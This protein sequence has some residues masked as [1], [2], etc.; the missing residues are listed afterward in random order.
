MSSGRGSASSPSG[1]GR[2]GEPGDEIAGRYRLEALLG[3]GAQGE[4]WR[5]VDA[6]VSAPVAI[7]LLRGGMDADPARIR[8]EAAALR[9]IRVPGVVRLQD[10]GVFGDR[11]FLVLDL[12]EGDPFP[13]RRMPVAWPDLL[14]VATALLDTLG[15]VHA[16]GIVHRDLKPANVLVRPDGAPV[17]LDFGLSRFDTARGDDLTAAGELLGTPAYLAP[18]QIRG[19]PVTARTDL[20]AVGVLLYEALSG[21]LPHEAEGWTGLLRQKLLR[22]PAPL[23]EVAPDVPLVVAAAVD[24][25]LSATPADRP[26]TALEAKHALL[27]ESAP[28]RRLPW[29]GPASIVD[30]TVMDLARGLSVDVAAEPGDGGTRFLFEVESRLR[31]AGETPA[32]LARSTR[33]FVSLEP[34]IG[35]LQ[36][37]DGATL[38]EAVSAAA[39]ALEAFFR[40]GGALLV[41]SAEALDPWSAQ[42]IEAAR[43]AG[44]VLRLGPRWEGDVRRLPALSEADL[45]AFFTGRDRLFHLR[46][47]AAKALFQRTSGRVGRVADELD[48][49]TRAG[50]ALLDGASYR[51]DRSSLDALE[52]G[53][54]VA[55]PPAPA[56]VEYNLLPAHLAELSAWAFL[57]GPLATAPFLASILGQ[58]RWRVEADIETLVA[59]GAG[60]LA[61]ETGALVVR[62]L[63]DPT[64]AWPQPRVR[65]AH[66]RIAETLPAGAPS[67]I[68]HLL[69]AGDAESEE[70]GRE[71]HATATRLFEEGRSGRAVAVIE[72]AL[73]G[74]RAAEGEAARIR[75]SLFA[76][77]IEIAQTDVVPRSADRIL[78]ELGRVANNQAGN[79]PDGSKALLRIEALA[80]AAVAISVEPGRAPRILDGLPPFAGGLSPKERAALERVK[81]ATRMTAA[82]AR[83]EGDETATLA[84]A[85]EWARSAGDPE[86]LAA[87]ESWRGRHCYR[88]GRFE[89]A[90]SHHLRAASGARGVAARVAARLNAA[91][92]MIEAFRP[93]D[94]ARVAK[95]A[96]EEAR[97]AR[98]PFLEARAEW[99]SRASAYRLE[100]ESEADLDLVE[101]VETLD[102]AH[103][104]GPVCLT[105]A[106][107]A[108]R[109]G[110]RESARDLALRAEKAWTAAR[111]HEELS[112]LARVLA[113]VCGEPCTEEERSR[114]LERAGRCVVPGVGI[115]VIGL[116]GWGG[117]RVSVPEEVESRLLIGLDPKNAR[118]RMDVLSRAECS[119]G[120]C[121]GSPS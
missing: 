65:A 32:I 59:G 17:I 43:G 96:G 88:L 55:R 107:F 57:S 106:T 60:H 69:K 112:L 78:Y 40:G 100:I 80:R 26:R 62:S 117:E 23:K 44:P 116:L 1:G 121:R 14:G 47:D 29:I 82:R 35:P 118:V 18:E 103:L 38:A 5:A 6:A 81:W 19:E 21:R 4:V 91:S 45:R 27:G 85:E 31:A 89:E 12:I 7:K 48:A 63:D 110:D 83:S 109:R 113:I 120:P 24:R 37:A 101:A 114:I 68:V 52:E 76:L 92:A 66:R 108:W 11:T 53:V 67:R 58:P 104:L 34:A 20:Y 61:G 70:I 102:V 54:I 3:R 30:R 2:L 99:L 115:Q 72:E 71:A 9:L 98:I 46:E 36:V 51:V 41:A 39:R 49:W 33:P 10:E 50:I 75:E 93:A 15:R 94:A 8:R 74:L 86:S 73:R 77:W 119:L 13:A 25:L 97:R 90:A 42:A 87:L 28:A 84:A 105:E 56:H 16:A 111:I 64:H 79:M 22:V 95:E